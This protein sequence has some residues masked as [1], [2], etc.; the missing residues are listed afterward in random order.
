MKTFLPKAGFLTIVFLIANLFFATASY[1]QILISDQEDYAPGSTCT[2]TGTGFLPGETVSMVVRHADETPDSGEDHDSWVVIA[3]E[4]GNFVTTWHVC[5]DDCLGST[6]RATADGLTSGLH[7]EVVFTDGNLSTVTVGAQSTSLVYGTSSSVTY[8]IVVT[9][10]NTSGNFSVTMSVTGL[11]TDIS[12]AVFSNPT[13]T[14]APNGT[15]NLTLTVT[16]LNTTKVPVSPP[17]FTVTATGG[18]GSG[19][20]SGTQIF[21]INKRALTG[22][23]TV[24]NKIYDNTTIATIA[25]RSLAG[26]VGADVVSYTGGTAA[27]TPNENVGTEKIVNA[28]GLS[29]SGVDAGNYTVN[30][31]AST[32]ANI[33]VRTLTITAAPNTKNYD[34][35]V[36]SASTPSITSGSIQTGDT[37]GFTETYDTKNKGVGKTL[38]PSGIVNDGNSGNNY[39]YTFVNSSAG[40]I[41]ART[42]TVTAAANT[43]AYDGTTTAAAI[44]TI[45]TGSLVSGDIGTFSETYDTKNQGSGKTMTPVLVSIVDGS[46]TDMAGNYSVTLA[47]SA[48]SVINKRPI[49]V[50][51]TANTKMYDGTTIAAAVPT[52][53]NG[54]LASGDVG[55]FN[56]TYTTKNQGVGKTMTPVLVSI[57]DGSNANMAGNY[58]VTLATSATGT[59]N[60]LPITIT[61]V[62]NTKTYDGTTSAA[63]VPIVTS[64]VV[65]TGDVAAFTEVYANKNVGSSKILIPAGIVNDGNSGN[66]YAYTFVNDVTGVI[67]ARALTING[68]VTSKIYD[69]G[70]GSSTPPAITSG[71]VQSGDIA[72]FTQTYDNRNVG[73]A[74]TLMPSGVVTDGNSGNNYTYIYFASNNGTITS[75]ALTITG[76]QSS[77]VYDATT[78][79]PSLPIVTIGAIQTGDVANFTQ[80]YNNK[81]VG[82]AKTLIPSGSVTD[83]NGGNNYTYTFN[84]LTTGSNRQITALAITVTAATNTKIY[85]GNTSAAATPTVTS[86]A[87]QSGD[88]TNFIEVYSNASAGTNKILIP[89]GSVTDGNNGNNYAYLFVNNT[90][91]VINKANATIVVAPYNVAYNAT[92]HTATVATATGVNGEDFTAD[93]VLT[94]TKHTDAGAYS[95]DSWSFAGNTNYNPA[96]ATIED[97]IGKIDPTIEVTPYN[98]AY[99]A[100]EHTATVTTATG[101]NGENFAADIVL[102]NTKHTDAGAYSSDSWSF[103]GNTNYNP[104]GATIEDVIGKIDPTIEVTPYN[105]AYNATEHTATVATATGVN[106]ENFTADIVLTNTKHTD[107]GTYS[108][109][110]WSFAGNTN[111][112]PAGATIEDVIGKIDPTIVVA[113][114][115]VAYDATEHTATV[116]TATGVN[117][118]DFTADIVLTNTKHT[119]AGT[120]SSDSWSFAGNTNYNPAG[121]TIEDVIGK[122]DPTI[123]VAPYNVAYDAAEHT[124]TVTTATGVNG[125][126]F[127][128]DIVLNNTKH[129]DAGTYSSDS[130]S[131]AGNTN[132]NPAGATIEDVIGKIDPTIVVA[133]YNVAYDAT[134]HTATVTTATGVNGENF[135]ADIVLTNTKHTDAGTYSSDS[136]SFAGNT[137]YNPAGATIE[138]VIGKIAPIIV[139][140]P[141]NVAYNATE[142]TAT[143]TTATG[144]NGENFTADIV[145]TNT[146]HTDA[147]TYSSDFWSFA[148]NTNY[149]PAGATIEDVIGKIDPTIV[150]APYNVAYNATEHTATVATAT[151]VNGEDFTADIVL[152][153]TKHTDAGTYSSDSW[154]FAGNT[155]YNPAG[156]TIEDVIGKIDPTIV[157]APYNVA[158]NATEHTA[159]VTTATGVNGED[160]TADIVLTNTKHTDAGTYSS[161]SWSFAGNTNYN[162]AGATI[163][164]VIGK[165]DPTI[166]V[167]PYNV[168]YNATE[169]TATVTTA[170][171]V[172]GENFMAD[173]VL[174]NTKHTDAG[175]YSSDSWSFAG[176]TN[177][178][179]AGA[180]I[181]DVIGKIDPTI[182]VAPYN[183]AYDATEH[184][185]TVNTAT[186]VNGENFTADIVLTNTKHT[187]AGTYSSDSWSFAGN[188]NYN[189]AGA[190]IEDVIGKIDPTIVVA[191]YNVAYD[192]TEHTATVTTATG[193]NGENFTADIVLTNTKHTD[194][195]TYSS[196]SWSFAGNTNYNPAGATI[197]DVIG[198][199]DP[200][201]VV[202]PYNVAY[203]AAEHTATVTTATGVNGENFT[204]DIVLTNTKHTDAGTY[205]SD[206]W[207]FAGNT[208]YNPAGATIEDIIGKIDPTIVVAPYNVAYDATEHTATVTTATGVNGENFTADIVLTNTKHTDAGT[209]SSDSWSFA[210]NTNYN[211]AGATIEDVIGKIDPTIVVTPYNVTYNGLAHTSLGTA[212]G[213]LSEALV[214]LVVS[215]TTHTNAGTYIADIWTFTDV[216][217]NYNNLNG[218]LNNFIGKADADVT[219]T[220]YT[221][222]YNALPHGATG[223]VTGVALDPTAAGSTLILGSSF[224]NAP[225]GT[226][227]WNFVGG[228]NYLDESGT[229]AIVIGKANTSVSATGGIF[230][231]DD[232][233]HAVTAYTTGVGGV[234]IT[235]PFTFSYVGTNCAGA[236]NSASAPS[237]PGTYTATATFDGNSNYNSSSSTASITIKSIMTATATGTNNVCNAGNSGTAT[238]IPALGKSP[239]TYLWSNSALT[240]SITG[241]VAGTYNVTVTDANHCIKTS[242]YTVTEPTALSATITTNNP[243]LYFGYSGDQTATITVKPKGGQA[244]YRVEIMMVDPLPVSP[245]RPIERVGGKLI[246][247]YIN[248]TGNESWVNVDATYQTINSSTAQSKSISSNP[249]STSFNNILLNGSYSVNVT[250]LTDARFIATVV[251]ANGCSYTIPYNQSVGVDA[252]DARCFAGNSGVAKVTLCHQTGNAKNPCTAICVDQSAVQEHLNHGDFL[253]K[254]TSNCKVPVSNAKLIQSDK[255]VVESTELT[256]NALS[257][258]IG[259]NEEIAESTEFTV[260]AFPNPSDNQFTL[261]LEGGSNEKVE[262]LVY[263]MLARRVKRIEKNSG[264]PIVFGE[265]FT[266]GEYLVLVRQGANAKSLNLIKK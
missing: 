88:V 186:G 94:N 240:Q 184:T 200:T 208:N 202:A 152:T 154:S 63:S 104:A 97:V 55:I 120:Y 42:L 181:E 227:N 64:G 30:T 198:K 217:G 46:S 214:G 162:P 138:D 80:V 196:D 108:S 52:I 111:Y 243:N 187:D 34:G 51:A 171:G 57:V 78:S 117:G 165:I 173:I 255:T 4:N 248:N 256:V 245:S 194:A 203:D 122:I 265:E 7:A 131:F 199:I 218:T 100:T 209:Y 39:A 25:T 59:I 177:Y 20:K 128:A 102:N 220:G 47:T 107:A 13:F 211:P 226:A 112:N 261:V 61:A 201:I 8:P 236:Y 105:V 21:T 191:P 160:F 259:S 29:L 249:V 169:H 244:P 257:N 40:V 229:V 127:T 231:F 252:E 204:A 86:G 53:T 237:A 262:V 135:T 113:P 11:P 213:V 146:K 175:T 66:N 144:V 149:N 15:Q 126:N 93:I 172:N 27:F 87:V 18:G 205:S 219:V 136:W 99:D 264:L 179:P 182:V 67:N 192:A 260:R 85:D 14:L 90:I 26:L 110:S 45:T 49:T 212:K 246:S 216:T 23:I 258:S 151:G 133:P 12:S 98:V 89:S 91:G 215:G 37:S 239:Y 197:E 60:M 121:A 118:E 10:S 43:K 48:N 206:S 170:T 3:D 95:S 141:Y 140:A 109:D 158:Y 266:S 35:T 72:A 221:G 235:T 36:S 161:D 125:E 254:C 32:T 79:S 253:G 232:N 185:A 189:P 222:V 210:G 153:N 132:Y 234:T 143:V 178:N 58:I 168:A 123:V 134:E 33:T 2:L 225:G 190:T 207:S 228:T 166:V 70:T 195:G 119:D 130:W 65:Q 101:V 54:T 263:D 242:S 50:T 31:A 62:T 22:S 159:T 114:Y 188:T 251:D 69:G 176:N 1:G 19:S 106:G 16:T 147:G 44:P 230:N 96:G 137:N 148:G 84:N 183:V 157:V 233:A 6:L 103:A 180:T 71:V 68:A 164:D 76:A 124:A 116:T 250:L 24:S 81:N 5:E 145:L 115:N 142:H 82:T 223:S 193:V 167:A 129:T 224:T 174:T 73:S 156:A 75:R 56:E 163:E 28:T 17:T 41:N 238:V 38:T 9:A 241:L 77:K 74:K 247:G 150:V 92:E 139:V 83:G 155:N